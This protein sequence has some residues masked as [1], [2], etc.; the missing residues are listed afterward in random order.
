MVW[1]AMSSTFILADPPIVLRPPRPEDAAD[2]LALGRNR[3]I[4]RMFG[5]DTNRPMPPLTADEVSRWLEG[6]VAHPHAWIVEHE[7]RLLGEV[8]LDNLND[9]DARARLSTGL[10]DAAKLGQG[11]GRRVVRLLLGHAFVQLK[12]HRVDLRVLPYNTRAIR[13]YRSCGFVEEGR[14][15]ESALVD[16][17]RHDDLIMSIL[18][19]EYLARAA[20]PR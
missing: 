7:D 14:E 19:H 4:V 16:G 13:C 12:L 8:R 2:R 10:L 3:E 6:I 18:R 15:R 9:H 17:E 5:G 20:G 1:A 11:L